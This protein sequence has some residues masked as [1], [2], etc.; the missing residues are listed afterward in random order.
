MRLKDRALGPVVLLTVGA[1]LFGAVAW[2]EAG[3]ARGTAEL[4]MKDY[5]SF[6]ADK[7]VRTA[8]SH[9]AFQATDHSDHGHELPRPAL[10][11]FIRDRAT[12]GATPLPEPTW[13]GVRYFFSYEARTQQLEFSGQ[14]P[15]RQDVTQLKSVLETYAPFCG[16]EQL[17]PFGQLRNLTTQT[18]PGDEEWVGWLQTDESGALLRVAGASFAV[19]TVVDDYL[20]PIIENEECDCPTIVLPESLAAVGSNRKSASFVIRDGSGRAHYRSEPEY[21]NSSRTSR[22]LS[23]ELPLPG[24]SV[25]VTVNPDVVE[26]LLPYG[27]AE[28]SWLVIGAL[29][30]L[31]GGSSALAI[32][33]VRKSAALV[34]LQQD[35]VG[36]VSHE[37]RTPLARIRLFNELLLNGQQDDA[38]KR[39]RYREVIDRECRRLG[40]L[41][42]NV[43]DFS[44]NRRGTLRYEMKALEVRELVDEG[45]DA[46]RSASD[47]QQFSLVEHL[48]DV[49]R[50]LGDRA[51]L[52]Q[53]LINLLDNAV[54][55][56]STGSRVDVTLSSRNGSVELSVRDEGPGIDEAQQARI[57]EPFYRVESGESQRVAGSGLGLALV[58]QTVDA[59]SGRVSVVSE[60]G[61][62]ATFVVELPVKE[63]VSP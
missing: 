48:E 19:D 17:V 6:I 31:V 14:T 5:A 52:Q 41:V 55:Y 8:A 60:P 30:A 29:F 59:H 45:L 16:S 20:R 4:L 28:F 49:P 15:S 50:I 47:E 51:A 58:K 2:R 21:E 24:W 37:L 25:E 56:S 27:G 9:E 23:K 38:R 57:F 61:S 35:F 26:P 13:P 34:R 46:F 7:F 44:R 10:R 3:R 18:I 11:R 33:S 42:D 36:N 63:E 39:S 32:R 54:K 1:A 40:F 62:G 43:L 22:L 53:V 12:G